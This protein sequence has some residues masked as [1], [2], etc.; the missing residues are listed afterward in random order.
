MKTKRAISGIFYVIFMW[1]MTT[2]SINTFT[3]L[4]LFI[5]ILSI[6]EMHKLRR[7]KTKILAYAYILI[8][9]LLIHF[10]GMLDS[11][12]AESPFDSSIILLMFLLTWTFDTFAYIVGTQYGKHKIM[13]SISPKKSWE[14]FIGGSIFTCIMSY[15][16]YSYFDT[17]SL[18]KIVIISLIIPFTASIGDFIASYYKR[19]AGVKD[20]GKL[21]PGHGGIIDRIDSFMIT[22]PCIYIINNI[23]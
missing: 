23:F 22:I 19:Q 2:Y 20:S 17:I 5:A 9:F 8:P 18:A 12:Y 11:D 15:L 10:F 3:I 6:Y 7:K 4:F 16:T 21:I 13:P 14:G 1:L